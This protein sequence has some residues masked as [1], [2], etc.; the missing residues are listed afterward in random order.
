MSP[1]SKASRPSASSTDA[2][3]RLPGESFPEHTGAAK[4]LLRPLRVA[5][6]E[7]E[8]G[9]RFPVSRL[10]DP[11][12]GNLGDRQIEQAAERLAPL[13]AAG[14]LEQDPLP[15]HGIGSPRRL[16]R[17]GL[18][19]LVPLGAAHRLEAGERVRAQQGTNGEAQLP[20]DEASRG[21]RHLPAPGDDADCAARQ[22]R[23]LEL[24]DGVGRIEGPPAPPASPSSHARRRSPGQSPA[25]SAT[26]PAATD[27]TTRPAGAG[28]SGA[29]GRAE[30]VVARSRTNGAAANRLM[31]GGV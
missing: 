3:S 1:T 2:S 15:G 18:E 30:T 24:A 11:P 25:L 26:E 13:G 29:P 8:R 9:L 20:L 27:S 21:E 22:R 19:F 4:G 5:G 10:P 14:P 6:G 12:G 16:P 31:I 7:A 28:G 23:R 17:P